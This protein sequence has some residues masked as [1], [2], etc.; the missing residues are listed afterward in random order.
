MKRLYF[1]GVCQGHHYVSEGCT[2][3][4][5]T[6]KS[7]GIALAVLLG[8]T[9]C[10][11]PEEKDT[12]VT[13]DTDTNGPIIEDTAV[14]ALYG[15]EM[16]DTAYWD[17]DGD[18]FSIEDGDCDD[19]NPDIHPDATETPSDGVDSNCNGEDDT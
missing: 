13:D 8:L 10:G 4:P 19:S 15:A 16:M 9:A 2:N 1:C 17:D 14:A 18:G 5:R 3:S 6:K 12:A 7:A 11:E